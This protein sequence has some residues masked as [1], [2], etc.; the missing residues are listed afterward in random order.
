MPGQRARQ[1]QQNDGAGGGNGQP[2]SQNQGGDAGN[3]A[4]PLPEGATLEQARELQLNATN[5]KRQLKEV[6]LER[7]N[8]LTNQQN[9]RRRTRHVDEPSPEDPRYLKAGKRCALAHLLWVEP[10]LFETELDPT[11][12]EARRY[13]DGEP[14]MQTQGDLLD[15]L[16]AA[17]SLRENLLQK[18]HFQGVFVHG[19]NEQRRNCATRA[20]KTCGSKIFS[21]LQEK[22]D[23]SAT[24]RDNQDFQRLLGYRANRPP[25]KQYRTLPPMLYKDEER[26]SNNHVFRHKIIFRLFRACAFGPA[27]VSDQGAPANTR[28][29]KSIAKLLGFKE[30]T[31]GMIAFAATLAR[32]C[33]SPDEEFLEKGGITGINYQKGYNHYKKLIHEGLMTEKKEFERG[34]V[35]G[36]FMKLMH[37]WNQEFFSNRRRPAANR[38]EGSD[39]EGNNSSDIDEA[40]QQIRQFGERDN[41]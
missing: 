25:G 36:P 2:D 5:Q 18:V 19:S 6:T 17:Q 7:D 38:G 35:Q 41:D 34:G 14:D 12:T 37:E 9:K 27:T 26:G 15:T 10:A 39:D 11:Y 31:P 24:R 8:L 3:E 13:E 28:G 30:V 33:I 23:T 16:A 29:Q 40:L 1:A 20:R 21:C 32:W 4:R 22:F